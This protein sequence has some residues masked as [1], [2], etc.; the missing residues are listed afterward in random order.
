MEEK[1]EGQE[2]T[3][4]AASDS[5]RALM[6]VNNQLNDMGTECVKGC[7]SVCTGNYGCYQTCV[8]MC[9]TTFPLREVFV[10]VA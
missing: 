10:R 5:A 9:H 4:T 2:V 6:R 8:Q 3:D 1:R 7:A